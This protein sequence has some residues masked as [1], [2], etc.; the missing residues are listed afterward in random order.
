[1]E[2]RELTEDPI[3]KAYCVLLSTIMMCALIYTPD[4]DAWKMSDVVTEI[5]IVEAIASYDFASHSPVRN[6][7]LHSFCFF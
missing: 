2:A 4:Q 5:Q 3:A 7:T 1:M 6:N